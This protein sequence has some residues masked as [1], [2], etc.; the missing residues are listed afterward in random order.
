MVELDK[1]SI[2]DILATFTFEL[3]VACALTFQVASFLVASFL[4]ASFLVELVDKQ[5]WFIDLD[6]QF[7]LLLLQ[8]F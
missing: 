2:I 6:I 1:L 5:L 3:M 4:V 8:F 7:E